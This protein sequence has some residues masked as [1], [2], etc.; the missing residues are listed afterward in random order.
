MLRYLQ[1]FN[2]LWRA[3]R[4]EF[5]LAGM[6]R[7]QVNYR[8]Q[9]R[10]TPGTQAHIIIQYTQNLMHNNVVLGIHM[11]LIQNLHLLKVLMSLI[12]WTLFLLNLLYIPMLDSLF[13]PA[14]DPLLLYVILFCFTDF[15]VCL[16]KCQ[17]ITGA[18]VHFISQL[19][20]YIMFEVRRKGGSIMGCLHF[21]FFM[22]KCFLN[23]LS[24]SLS[25]PPLSSFLSVWS[26]HGQ[27]Y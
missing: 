26:V 10:T 2:F 18:L 17:L 4:I 23:H 3:K 22:M 14:P 13:R 25:L 27:N 9:L 5:I 12:Y 8:K 6:W 7:K 24:L 20:Y 11:L 1:I 19:Q 15:H 16:H 21:F